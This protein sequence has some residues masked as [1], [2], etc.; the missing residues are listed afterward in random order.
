[1]GCAH[2]VCEQTCVADGILGAVS[3]GVIQGVLRV[4]E[5][6]ASPS[7]L[8]SPGDLLPQLKG[9]AEATGQAKA[10]SCSLHRAVWLLRSVATLATRG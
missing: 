10:G 4:L 5:V 9:C 3:I 8:R 2:G 7:I 6:E 1:M